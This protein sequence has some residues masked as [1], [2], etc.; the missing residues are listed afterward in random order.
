MLFTQ[1]THLLL[2][3]FFFSLLPLVLFLY[4]FSIDGFCACNSGI[5]QVR[6]VEL[7][8]EILMISVRIF[9]I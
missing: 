1:D 9:P 3:T 7:D 4:L 8:T 2:T 5:Q 6:T